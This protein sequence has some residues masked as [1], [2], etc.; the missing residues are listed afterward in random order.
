MSL[1]TDLT[2]VLLT[3]CPEAHP[4]PA[5]LGTPAPYITWQHIG[6]DPLRFLDKSRPSR[7][8]AEIQVNTWHTTPMAAM[9]LAQAADE[10]LSAALPLL[11]ATPLD[12]PI[13]GYDE[14]TELD[15]YLQSFSI[16]G[17]DK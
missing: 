11:Q 13:K 6:G 10:A 15:G 12:E 9:L 5:P 7:R 2:A 16:W 3:V 14:S 4:H 1:E 17:N 8:N